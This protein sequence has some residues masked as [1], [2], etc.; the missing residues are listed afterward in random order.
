MAFLDN[1]GDIILDAVLTDTGRMRLA[2]GDGTFRIEK[3]ALG[4]DEI[5]YTRYDTQLVTTLQ[6]LTILQTPV[7]EAFA[8]NVGSMK[9]KLLS[10]LNNNQ[11]YLPVIRLYENGDSARFGS[12][13]S[14]K[15][16]VLVD[17]TTVN[18]V[19]GSSAGTAGGL[20]IG[21]LNGLF[22]GQSSHNI[23]ADQ[24]MDNAAVLTMNADMRETQYMVK[25]DNRL[26]GLVPPA[27]STTP[28]QPAFVDDDNIATYILT[29]ATDDN[30]VNIDPSFLV[31]PSQANQ[32]TGKAVLGAFGS[33]I[34]FRIKAA[35]EVTTS[36][37]LFTVLGN[38]GTEAIGSLASGDYR[39]IDT[40]VNVGGET[41][42]YNI[43]I[44]IR[45]VKQT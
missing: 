12:G 16:I 7:L 43:D 9:Y 41:T 33:R 42:G 6:G 1:S 37:Y 27:N 24:G 20:P 10:G 45:Y 2:K 22:V 29:S 31:N 35:V 8:N 4:D 18:T 34:G 23:R 26:G 17:N 25:M 13:G 44:P 15:F 30:Y 19:I 11:F 28:A 21:V 36:N 38:V 3:F 32:A 39:Y 14:A 5:D 40:V